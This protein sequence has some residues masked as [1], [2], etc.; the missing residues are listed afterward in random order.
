MSVAVTE[1]R[2]A[3]NAPDREY[4]LERTRNIGIAAH[5]DAGKTTT[6]E[7]ILF[8]TGLIHKMGE[9][10]DGNTVT[11][12]MS[13]EK[14]R[15]ITITSAAI[16]CFWKQA[17]DGL[18]KSYPDIPHRINI[19]DTPGHVDFTAEVERSMRVLDGA[20]AVFCGVAGVQPQSETVWRQATKYRVPRIAFVNKMDRT[21]A[22]FDYVVSE[23]REKLG[24]YAFPVVLPLGAEDHL[25]GVIDVISQKAVVYDEAD[26]S[27]LSHR[28]VDLSGDQK[29]RAEAAYMELLDAVAEKDDQI[30][31]L[32]LEEKPVEPSILKAAI[33]RLTCQ[34]EFVPVLGGS[35]FKNKGVHAVVDA[36]IDY[37]PSPVEV[38]AA[39]A[40]D[41]T[42][43]CQLEVSADDGGSFCGLAFKLWTDPFV[44]KLVFIRVYRGTLKKGDTLLNT[45]TGKRERAS[46]LLMI[47]ADKRTDCEAVYSGDIAAIVGVRQVTT[48]DTLSQ[49]GLQVSLEPPTFPE[50]VI[51]MAIE[52]KTKADREKLSEGL[53]RLSEEDP[54]FRCYTN[55]ETGQLI[56][57]GMGELHLEIIR[58]RLLRE[59]KVGAN[60]GAPQIA[61]RETITQAAEGEGKFIRQSGGRGQY[62]HAK[63][64]IRPLE[65]GKGISVESQIVGGV[66]P[67]EFVP[68]VIAGIQE[69][70]AGGVLAN[71][72]MVDLAVEVFDGSFHEVDATE[73][74]YKMAGIFAFKE[75][76]ERAS[77]TLLEPL[78]KV[79]VTTPDEYQG[80]I[81]GD[82]NR[83]RGKILS[84]DAKPQMT[85]ISS[86][87]PL[88]EMF[89]YAT[90]A[91]SLS[92]GR[93]SYSMEPCRFDP[94]PSQ[95]L[96]TML[97]T[98]S[99]MMVNR[100]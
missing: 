66:I 84:I 21:G 23:M 51:S 82:L 33:R 39:Q 40:H 11:D 95:I 81:L 49:Q 22:D 85:L 80:D 36:V 10:H 63:V 70:I 2:S 16:T 64:R 20:V 93:A 60:A 26:L 88:A 24:A 34:L 42:K 31:E 97:E 27:G 47:Q 52:P 13:Q 57:A 75:A 50:P 45:R 30:M 89:G 29:E 12:W 58:D 76:A 96:N 87:V 77:L 62:G 100:D 5:I 18:F 17:K 72:P 69:A 1:E 7:R 67:K 53:Q 28:V 92:K 6:T 44:G 4:S 37:L 94:V 25:Q 54:T 55:E 46:R 86:E 61:Y 9:V 68:H 14:E 59:F 98:V 56:I 73:L 19:I 78:M 65:R 79:E 15:G 41:L 90:A 35:A 91:R 83:R 38:P 99:P 32:V 3:L 71:Y 43:D 48:G 74:A 8:Y